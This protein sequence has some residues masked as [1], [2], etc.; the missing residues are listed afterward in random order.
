M[1]LTKIKFPSPP[2]VQT[3]KMSTTTSSTVPSVTFQGSC[4]LAFPTQTIPSHQTLKSNLAVRSV[5]L[6]VCVSLSFNNSPTTR[7]RVCAC[8]C[9]CLNY[10]PFSSTT[11]LQFHY[12]CTRSIRQSAIT[13]N[14]RSILPATPHFLFLLHKHIIMAKQF[15]QTTLEKTDEY[16]CNSTQWPRPERRGSRIITTSVPPPATSLCKK[17]KRS[18]S[19]LCLFTAVPRT[20]YF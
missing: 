8:M 3:H 2:H 11:P 10:P 17:M 9:V 18:E 15:K 12:S 20:R 4:P 7:H 14:D 5:F 13:R 16:E 19:P 6:R 1:S